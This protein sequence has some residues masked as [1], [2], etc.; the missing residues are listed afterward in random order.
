MK[1]QQISEPPKEWWQYK[2][3]RGTIDGVKQSTS[4][5]FGILKGVKKRPY[6]EYMWGEYKGH[7][8]E[9]YNA[10]KYNQFLI[11]V[12]KNMEFVKSK[13]TYWLGGIKRVTKS[14]SKKG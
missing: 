6:G 2:D 7:K 12:S 14:E 5:T 10:F 3:T 9:V 8:I 1:I 11:Y 13:L 4:L